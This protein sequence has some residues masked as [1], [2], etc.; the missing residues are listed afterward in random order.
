MVD[1][2]ARNRLAELIRHLASG[3]LSNEEFEDRVRKSANPALAAVFWMG[4]WGLYHDIFEYRLV[5]RDRLS[6]KDRRLVARWVLFL[7]SDLEYEWPTYPPLPVL[8][9]LLLHLLTLGRTTA[10]YFP[11]WKAKGDFDV[12]PFVHRGD[13]DAALKAP[14][15]LSATAS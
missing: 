8:L 12:W 2:V 13:F 7:K 3:Q 6:E 1:R 9:W 11:S 14:P 10:Y 4:A 15:Y 5:G